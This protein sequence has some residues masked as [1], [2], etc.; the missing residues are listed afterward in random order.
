MKSDTYPTLREVIESLE[1][2]Y[3]TPEKVTLVPRSLNEWLKPEG[4]SICSPSYRET[5]GGYGLTGEQT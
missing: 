2:Q 3:P 5:D 1:R 4:H